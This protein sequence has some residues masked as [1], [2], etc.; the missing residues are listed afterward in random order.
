M[1]LPGRSDHNNR[2]PILPE[3]RF[4]TLGWRVLL[5]ATLLALVIFVLLPFTQFIAGDTE[6]R[7]RIYRVDVAPPPPPPPPPDE[8]P[9]EEEPPQ[10]EPPP[11]FEQPPPEMDLSQLEAAL[12]PG[13]G[14]TAGAFAVEQFEVAADAASELDIFSVDE[15]DE[16]P[17]LLSGT[18]PRHPQNLLR[19]RVEGR[20]ELRVMIDVDGSVEVLEVVSSSRSEFERP[21]IQAAEN[22]RYE[23]PTAGGKPARTIFILPMEFRIN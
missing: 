10:D 5:S 22:F 13:L 3:P 8:P 15:L 20:V 21:A 4:Q 7:S 18:R 6:D 19:E 9:P 12:D 1:S 2:G 16:R 23:T 14:D 11:Q 17:R